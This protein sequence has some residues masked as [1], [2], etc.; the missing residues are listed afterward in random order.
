MCSPSAV[1][2]GQ[3]RS[4]HY[5]AAEECKVMNLPASKTSRR[6]SPLLWIAVIPATASAALVFLIRER[7]HP[8]IGTRVT[9]S[10]ADLPSRFWRVISILGLFAIVNFPD[11][12]LLLRA[13]DLGFEFGGVVALYVLYNLSYAAL[14]YPAGA[15]SDRLNRRVVFACGLGIFATAYLGFGMTTTPAWLC[16]LF[17]LY[18]AYAALT[19][20]VSRAWIADL[21]PGHARGTALRIHA[22]LSGVGLL[23]AGV[24]AGLAWMGT[25][26]VPFILSGTLVAVIA[27]I[28]MA[29]RHIGE[30]A[31]V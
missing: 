5:G 19:D 21:V 14:S 29:S 24:W 7:P 25:G 1:T 22:A 16:V 31:A 3:F 28:L 18:G 26:R 11:T 17:P 8:G 9:W 20:G 15:I 27:V 4:L 23:A 13:K 12:L 2:F 10:T 30:P 6:F